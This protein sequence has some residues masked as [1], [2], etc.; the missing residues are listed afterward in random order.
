[1][2]IEKKNMGK[3][4]RISL[5]LVIKG[6]E[7]S[8]EEAELLELVAKLLAFGAILSVDSP[9]TTKLHLKKAKERVKSLMKLRDV[10]SK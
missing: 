7:L 9:D 2:K 3:I 10:I 1:M 4:E 5:E 6:R 8:K